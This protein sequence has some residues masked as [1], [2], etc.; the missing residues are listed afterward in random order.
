MIFLAR[1]FI[2]FRVRAHVRV[3]VCACTGMCARTPG[4]LEGGKENRKLVS[5]RKA[6]EKLLSGKG[7][8]LREWHGVA[9][10]LALFVVW[11]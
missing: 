6:I 4:G 10:G 5:Y 11:G 2:V 3:Y 9:R 7:G 1:N 8:A